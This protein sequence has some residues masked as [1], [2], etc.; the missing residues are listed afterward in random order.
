MTRVTALLGKAA[1]AAVC[2]GILA[3]QGIAA[4]R[5]PE[6]E[7][8]RIDHTRSVLDE[9]HLRLVSGTLSLG[10]SLLDA[11]SVRRLYSPPFVSSDFD[12]SLE[13]NGRPVPL[14]SFVWYP[15]EIQR[16]GRSGNIAA[17]TSLLPLRQARAFLELIRLENLGTSNEFVEIALRVRGRSI[18]PR[19][20]AG[21]TRL[22]GA[23]PRPWHRPF[24]RARK[25]TTCPTRDSSSRT[26]R[27]GSRHASSATILECAAPQ[28]SSASPSSRVLRAI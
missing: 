25:R 4:G 13:V 1:L 7:R 11:A 9:D 2:V 16:T 15:N 19:Q 12:L 21:S 10:P 22:P 3:P 28:P 24:I 18:A 6:F 26:P 8:Y 14:E 23:P 20:S 17:H 5:I 27:A